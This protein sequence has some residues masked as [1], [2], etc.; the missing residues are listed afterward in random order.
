M[1]FRTIK[2]NKN[3]HT[4]LSYRR[5]RTVPVL[6]TLTSSSTHDVL[7]T[8][9][10]TNPPAFAGE[11]TLRHKAPPGFASVGS[12]LAWRAEQAVPRVVWKA[13]AENAGEDSGLITG[14]RTV[15]LEGELMIPPSSQ[16]SFTFGG[17]AAY[18]SPCVHDM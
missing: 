6:L 9:T 12:A 2:L 18:V 1:R 3:H 8:L 11:L 15:T 5:G 10:R 17:L 13:V 7:S 14:G 16:P 4:Q